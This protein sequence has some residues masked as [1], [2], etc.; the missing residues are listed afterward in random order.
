M[1]VWVTVLTCVVMSSAAIGVTYYVYIFHYKK[2]EKER[3]R[4]NDMA[5]EMV[6]RVESPVIVPIVPITSIK[7][8]S[9][10][11]SKLCKIGMIYPSEHIRAKGYYWHKYPI[12]S[13]NFMFKMYLSIGSKSKNSLPVI[14]DDNY[15]IIIAHQ[16]TE[17]DTKINLYL[18]GTYFSEYIDDFVYIDDISKYDKRTGIYT[19]D[20]KPLLEVEGLDDI[21]CK[22]DN[23][24][25]KLHLI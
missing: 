12:V 8:L 25:I 1:N 15:N 17:V 13:D 3:E 18:S 5:E 21:R 24:S 20:N 23:Q 4:P 14:M 2:R 11:I 6:S 19:F 16:F 22:F 10:N 7:L 9:N